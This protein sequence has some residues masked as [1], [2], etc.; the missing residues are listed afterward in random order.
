MPLVGASVGPEIGMNALVK[1]TLPAGWETVD[2][3]LRHPSCEDEYYAFG[4]DLVFVH[5]PNLKREH[6]NNFYSDNSVVTWHVDDFIYQV[7]ADDEHVAIDGISEYDDLAMDL[8]D[9]TEEQHPEWKAYST[10]A[11]RQA[12]T[13]THADD[14]TK[15]ASVKKQKIID[16]RH[17]D[18]ID[19]NNTNKDGWF[20]WDADGTGVHVYVMDTGINFS[21]EAFRE[22][23]GTVNWDGVMD[24]RGASGLDCG[25]HGSNVASIAVGGD[26]RVR[27]T[28]KDGDNKHG[29]GSN[30][31]ITNETPTFPYGLGVARGAIVHSVRAI[32]CT[33]RTNHSVFAKAISWILHNVEHPAV[34]VASLGAPNNPVMTEG[35]KALLEANVHVVAAA[36]NNQTDACTWTPGHVDGVIAVGATGTSYNKLGFSNSGKCVTIWAPSAAVL[37]ADVVDETSLS[38]RTG[39]SQACPLVAGAVAQYLQVFPDATPAQIR[40]ALIRDSQKGIVRD[41]PDDGSPNR[42]LYIDRSTDPKVNPLRAVDEVPP[43]VATPSPYAKNHVSLRAL[44]ITLVVVVAVVGASFTIYRGYSDSTYAS[45]S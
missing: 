2:A 12:E 27:E 26:V 10:T 9:E 15:S 42:F 39:T 6:T 17:L 45:I 40:D 41:L 32:G 44:L 14:E 22:R 19:Q 20:H 8:N 23:Q 16:G 25:V 36:G 18:M 3:L 21:H 30:T 5:C 28:E 31:G 37:G 29:F 34:V 13:D 7:S 4:N 24:G 11:R 38:H 1:V 35:T 43:I 33:G